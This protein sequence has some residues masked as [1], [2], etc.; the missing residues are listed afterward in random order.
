MKRELYCRASFIWKDAV[1]LLGIPAKQ[2]KRAFHD[3]RLDCENDPITFAEFVL[4]GSK[5]TTILV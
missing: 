2:V 3:A 1:E 5:D 4:K